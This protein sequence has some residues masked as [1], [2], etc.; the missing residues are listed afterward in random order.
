MLSLSSAP[1]PVAN[2][3]WY[4]D[5]NTSTVDDTLRI[6]YHSPPVPVPTFV[7]PLAIST[8]LS[9]TRPPVVIVIVLP[10]LTHRSP[11][12]STSHRQPTNWRHSHAS[13]ARTSSF[14]QW[15]WLWLIKLT[16]LSRDIILS[17]LAPHLQTLHKSTTTTCHATHR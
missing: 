14:W 12:S 9:I 1:R 2:L 4:R 13:P 8:I 5:Y 6:Q 16:T 17:T 3:A 10:Q 11:S 7:K 15:L